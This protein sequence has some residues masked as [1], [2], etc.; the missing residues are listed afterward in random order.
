MIISNDKFNMTEEPTSQYGVR[1]RL[2]IK[3]L[4]KDRDFTGYKCISQNSMGSTEGTIHLH[5]HGKQVSHADES[6][7]KL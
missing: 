4:S 1:M 2:Q 5:L 6:N 3:N 7:M